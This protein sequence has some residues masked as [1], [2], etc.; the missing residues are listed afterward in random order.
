MSIALRNHLRMFI[1]ARPDCLSVVMVLVKHVFRRF[2]VLNDL[3]HS[4][5]VTGNVQREGLTSIP[6]PC[7]GVFLL[8]S[9]LVCLFNKK[10][11]AP[12]SAGQNPFQNFYFLIHQIDLQSQTK[13]V[14][15]LAPNAVFFS[16]LARLLVLQKLVIAVNSPTSGGQEDSKVSQQ[17]GLRLWLLK[18]TKHENNHNGRPIDRTRMTTSV[19]GWGPRYKYRGVYIKQS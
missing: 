5:E 4:A 12:L 18:R 8:F 16:L 11:S 9:F 7:K 14:G 15:I 10:A 17:F 6:A 3:S 13:I 2:N 19:E 1:I